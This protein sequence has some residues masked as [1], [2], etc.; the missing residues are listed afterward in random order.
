V[1]VLTRNEEHNITDCLRSVSW[2]DKLCVLDSGSTDGTVELARQAGAEVQQR[3]FVNYA[4]QRDAAL[5]LFAAQWILFVDADERGT[6]ELGAEVRRVIQEGSAV[7]WWVPRRNYIWGR[8]IRHAGWY[9]D[10]QLRLLKRGFSRYDPTR[11][12]HEIVQLD[13]A[14]GHLQNPLTHYN[15]AT[16]RQFLDKQDYYATYEASVLVRQGIQPRPHSLLLQPLRE[17][18]RRYITLQGYKDGAHGLLL[19][20][21]MAYY[22]GVAYWRARSM[23]TVKRES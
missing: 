22:T 14:E 16:V 15:Y 21:L 5:Q 6:P 11:E 17:F 13:G 9:P 12:V 23:W 20:L 1:V 10:C 2:A 3:P 19:S 7:G 18:R 8:W 4:D